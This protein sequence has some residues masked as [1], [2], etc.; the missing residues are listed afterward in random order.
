M[1]EIIGM[2]LVFVG[3]G[4]AVCLFLALILF[5]VGGIG[6][7]IICCSVVGGT[8]YLIKEAVPCLGDACKIAWNKI[9]EA[10]SMDSLEDD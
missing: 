5:L 10:L 9:K 4:L 7:I 3:I 1:F 6:F 8:L 2:F